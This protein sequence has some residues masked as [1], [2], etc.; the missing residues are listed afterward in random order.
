MK[1]TTLG[2][3]LLVIS[4]ST[5]A[6]W[7]RK[8][9]LGISTGYESNVFLNPPSLIIEGEEIGRDELWQSGTFQQLFLNTSFVYDT[10]SY[11]LKIKANGGASL[12]QTDIEANRRTY[13]LGVAYRRKIGKRKYLEIAPKY[14]RRQRDGVNEADAVLRT[15]FSFRQMII[16][17]H[18]DYYLGGRAWLKTQVGY[19]RKDY[20]RMEGEEL[21][22]TSP[23]A[24]ITVS[25]KWLD[26]ITTKKLTLTASNQ[27][28]TYTDIELSSE[29]DE[30]PIFENEERQWNYRRVDTEFEFIDKNDKYRI[31]FGLYHLQRTDID[32]PNGYTQVSPAVQFKYNITRLTMDA[33]F[34]YSLRKYSGLSPGRDNDTLLRYDYLR[35]GLGAR[36]TLKNNASAF[37]KGKIVNRESNS[38][39]LEAIGFRDYFTGFVELGMVFKF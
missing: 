36:Y 27:W 28:R 34:K 33:E 1:K 6:Q 23:F 20:D 14:N 32:G 17:L 30:D 15:P 3:F 38:P 25:K 19:L 8:S 2:I 35:A 31:L 16:P 5:F 26:R 21:K 12:Y 4:Q 39:D 13:D 18:F 11:R 29:E 37:L 10:L 7:E 24:Q 22:Y 9:K